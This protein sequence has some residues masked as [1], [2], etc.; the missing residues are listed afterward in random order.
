MTCNIGL[1]NFEC[2]WSTN[3]HGE[4]PPCQYLGTNMLVSIINLMLI[5]VIYVAVEGV[6]PP[7]LGGGQ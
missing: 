7:F 1:A 2:M 6:M 5:M 4:C 3:R